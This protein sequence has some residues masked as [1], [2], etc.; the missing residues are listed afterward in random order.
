MSIIAVERA[1]RE[2]NREERRRKK[3]ETRQRRELIA[4]QQ[5]EAALRRAA[6]LVQSNRVPIEITR[7]AA[8]AA[9]ANAAVA[10]T[11]GMLTPKI[12]MLSKRSRSSIVVS[13]ASDL[14]Q[15]VTHSKNLWTKY[16]AIAKEHNQK[17]NWITVAKE[18]GIHVKVR[19][20]YAR[21]H[22]RALQRGFDFVTCGHYKI[23]EHPQIFLEPLN[24]NVQSKK[25]SNDSI[26][27]HSTESHDQQKQMQIVQA[28]QHVEIEQA[29]AA[30]AAAA[31]KAN[32]VNTEELVDG[33]VV[34]NE[35]ESTEF[36]N[37]DSNAS[38]NT[39]DPPPPQEGIPP[40]VPDVVVDDL[41][42]DTPTTYTPTDK[43]VTPK[44]EVSV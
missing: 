21:M 33:S 39:P 43:L 7:G 25:S 12:D 6:E 11:N 40:V 27:T 4:Q 14:N 18:L 5:K 9:A 44:A 24:S 28:A 19:E 23:K 26:E 22:A 13:T 3:L 15:I 31:M 37:N 17:V 10:A 8:V 2:A 42:M 1:A 32:G 30:A 16:N 35:I 41:S 38:T 34:A 36:E 20:K 29:A